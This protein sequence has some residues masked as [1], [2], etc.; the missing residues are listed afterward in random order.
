[1]NY[2]K[3]K[4]RI[5]SSRFI[6][7]DYGWPGAYFITIATKNRICYF[8]EIN[9]YYV[10]NQLDVN[11]APTGLGEI[12]KFQWYEIPKHFQF[13]K[14]DAFVVMPD[15]IHGII[16][17]ENPAVETR[18]HPAVETR[19][20]PAVETR[21]HPAV[22]TRLIASLHP[23]IKSK[24]GGI[25][26]NNNPMLMNN[27]SRI[28]RWYKG[29]CT[30]EMRKIHTEFAWQPRFY[31]RIIRNEA[32]FRYVQDYIFKNPEQWAIKYDSLK[33]PWENSQ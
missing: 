11:F 2:Y 15:H 18:F 28:I 33:Y 16:I 14:L 12:A 8:G 10:G 20:H 26:G 13:I 9:K 27:I 30:F 7:W 17:I 31:D 29:R 23:N 5:N 22:E 21:F 1:M 3:G 6:H 32:E 4:Y 25:T 19:F 24:T